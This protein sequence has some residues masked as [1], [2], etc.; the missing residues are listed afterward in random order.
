[1]KGKHAQKNFGAVGAMAPAP[2]S[3]KTPGGKGGGGAEG[4]RIQ[5]P[6]PAAPP[7]DPGSCRVQC[8]S[9]MCLGVAAGCAARGSSTVQSSMHLEQQ[10]L[11]HSQ[12]AAGCC[13]CGPRGRCVSPPHASTLPG[14]RAV[15]PETPPGWGPLDPRGTC[16]SP[17]APGHP[18]VGRV[19]CITSPIRFPGCRPLATSR[20]GKTNATF[21]AEGPGDQTRIF[22]VEGAG[23][24]RRGWP[25]WSK[26]MPNWWEIGVSINNPGH[27][28]PSTELRQAAL[29]RDGGG[30]CTPV[31]TFQLGGGGG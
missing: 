4:C 20:P 23:G 27:T 13:A 2:L 31:R 7:C 14:P 11:L 5:G 6:G 26:A 16:G 12:A 25:I 9:R 18:A 30:P 10:Q 19:S 21:P 24:R 17:P 8:S 15:T 1:M 28:P 29:P 22:F 3:L